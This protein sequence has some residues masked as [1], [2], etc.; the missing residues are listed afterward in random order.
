MSKRKSILLAGAAAAA[1]ALLLAVLFLRRDGR[2]P[3]AAESSPGYESTLFDVSRVHSVDILVDDWDAF[4][5]TAPE[6]KY[7]SC[8]VVIDGETVRDVGI[9]GKGNTSLATV[10]SMGSRRYSFKI[11]FDHYQDGQSYRGLDKLCLNNLIQDN[12]CM[13][14]Y[15][16]YRLMA[17]FGVDAPLCAYV[18]VTVNG[19]L[20]RR[21]LRISKIIIET[22]DGRAAAA[23]HCELYSYCLCDHLF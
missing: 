19:E 8:A 17:D 14:D 6:E 10:A 4:L 2:G 23:H 12:T 1:L 7:A 16:A 11:E 18:W 13:K 9:R 3:A 5:E 15:L 20:S 21:L 22:N